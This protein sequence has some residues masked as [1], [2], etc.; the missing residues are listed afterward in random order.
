MIICIPAAEA[1]SE[2]LLGQDQAYLVNYLRMGKRTPLPYTGSL[3]AA[4]YDLLDDGKKRALVNTA[5]NI[6]TR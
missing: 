1:A 6:L 4:D 2:N 5:R 3:L